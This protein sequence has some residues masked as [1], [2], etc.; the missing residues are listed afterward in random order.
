MHAMFNAWKDKFKPYILDLGGK[1]Q[2][3]GKILTAAGLKDG[4]FVEA[5]EIVGG[6]IVPAAGTYEQAAEV[7]EE[8]PGI[9]APGVSIEIREIWAP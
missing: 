2:A 5:K 1:L 7:A 6:Y 4:P 9:L 3:G 8:C